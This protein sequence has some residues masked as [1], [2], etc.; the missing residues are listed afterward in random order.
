MSEPREAIASALNSYLTE[1]QVSKLIDEILAIT[2]RASAEFSCK[3][4]GQRQMAWA[5]ISD[6]KAVAGA[7]T[8]LANQAFGRPSEATE[9]TE[10]IVYKRLTKLEEE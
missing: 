2:K 8:D 5:E 4:C 6:A 9:K 7:L 3:S 1:E 10:P